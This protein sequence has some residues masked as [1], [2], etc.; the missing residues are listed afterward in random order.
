MAP[1]PAAPQPGDADFIALALQQAEAA[2]QAGEVPVGAVVVDAQGQVLGAGYNR[3]ITDSDPTA[4][5][6]IVAL[7][8]AARRLGNYR[9][10]GVSLYVT[11]EPCVMCIGAML[12][13]RLA[14]V[15][16]GA[17]D[18]KT[19]ACGSVLDVGA[20]VRLNHQTTITGGVLAEPCGNLLRQ[21]FRARRAKESPT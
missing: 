19:G 20:V 1:L 21:F 18:P 15:V 5:A 13:A 8:A 7:R 4:H 6:E 10:P 2:W 16:Y 17:A 11:L 3:T 12:H 9:L 14:R